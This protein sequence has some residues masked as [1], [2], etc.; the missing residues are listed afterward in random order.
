M[1]EDAKTQLQSFGAK[2]VGDQ[3]PAEADEQQGGGRTV[4]AFKQVLDSRRDEIEALLPRH[5]SWDRLRSTALEAVRQNPQL[6]YCEGRSLLGAVTKAANDGLLPDGR[7]G[8]ITHYKD[9]KRN[10][11]IAQWNP[12]MLG[13]RKRA[14]ELDKIIVDAH[15]VYEND[16]F[17][18][19]RGDRP[20]I[21]HKAPPLGQPRGNIVGAYA[22]YRQGDAILHREVVSKEDIQKARSQSKA[23]DSLMWTKFAGEGAKK[24]A[25]RRGFKTVQCSEPL[26]A[27]VRREDENFTLEPAPMIEGNIGEPVAIEDQSQDPEDAPVAPPK[28]DEQ[29]PEIEGEATEVRPQNIPAENVIYLHPSQKHMQAAFEKQGIKVVIHDDA[30]PMSTQEGATIT[31]DAAGEVPPKGKP[32]AAK[33]ASKAPSEPQ[34]SPRKAPAKRATTTKRKSKEAAPADD[35][36]PQRDFA[37][38]GKLLRKDMWKA[39]TAVELHTIWKDRVEPVE[40]W[41][42]DELV[43]VERTYKERLAKV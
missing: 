35:G 7:E 1:T 10:C 5:V 11:L 3:M 39:K 23:P 21:K 14:T 20:F 30:K 32:P 15:V 22:I 28:D 38:E 9:K 43:A 8:I 13:L 42:S 17:E 18:H 6:L 12:M 19:E 33:P 16:E 40:A 2:P 27:I 37:A 34:R 26:E 25:V 41:P 24:V 31:E 36:E 4:A 29:G